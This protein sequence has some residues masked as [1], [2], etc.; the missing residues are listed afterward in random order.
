MYV[1]ET[2]IVNKKKKTRTIAISTE[3][4]SFWRHGPHMAKRRKVM[5]TNAEG[6]RGRVGEKGGYISLFPVRQEIKVGNRF[7][8][9]P[10]NLYRLHL[11]YPSRSLLL[12]RLTNNS[13]K[14]CDVQRNRQSLMN[15][16]SK[17]E[18]R[19][20]MCF[21]ACWLSAWKTVMK[22]KNVSKG[23]K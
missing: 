18:H 5:K 7:V 1:R 12:R 13:K 4:A 21:L 8:L 6:D 10:I 16:K 11:Q 2:K 20:L 19:S 15:K 3:V 14:K 22:S 9:L 17:I 23:H